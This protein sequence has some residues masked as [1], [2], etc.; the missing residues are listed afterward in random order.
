MGHFNST[1]TARVRIVSSRTANINW[2]EYQSQ[3]GA[4]N[5]Y[6]GDQSSRLPFLMSGGSIC[7]HTSA[8]ILAGESLH[9]GW[10]P[11]HKLEK[12]YPKRVHIHHRGHIS[13][14]CVP[15]VKAAGL[16]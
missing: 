2:D 8:Q 6:D 1:Y 3:E 15:E 14:P 12:N 11:G 5:T 4:C 16:I 13:E 10:L 9:N 7:C